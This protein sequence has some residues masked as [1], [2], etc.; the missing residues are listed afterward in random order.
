[1]TSKVITSSKFIL[2][3]SIISKIFSFAGSILLAR[4]LFPADYGYLTF[5]TVFTAFLQQIGN[6]GIEVFY[7]QEKTNNEKEEE[8]ILQTVFKLR[9]F[10]NGSLFLIQNIVAFICYLYMEESIVS[11]LLSIFSI[12][13]IIEISST[14]NSAI[15]KKELNFKPIA[16]ANTFRDVTSVVSRVLFA[17]LGFGPLCFGLGAVIGS[18]SQAI[19]ILRAKRMKVDWKFWDTLYFRRV[20]NF[21]KHVLV[22]SIGSYGSQ[23]IDK[24][25]MVSFFDVSKIGFYS[26]G[27]SNAGIPFTYIF[28][29]QQQLILS[30]SANMK[31]KPEL[32]L[33]R[34]FDMA[35]IIILLTGP[36]YIFAY[37]NC[38]LIVTS[39]FGNKWL[40]AV[41][42]VKVF[43]IY[44]FFLSFLT[45]FNGLLTAMGRPDIISRIT[46]LKVIGL[47]PFLFIFAVLVPDLVWYSF[48][49]SMISVVFD[50]IKANLGAKKIGGSVFSF[51]RRNSDVVLLL[52]LLIGMEMI[53]LKSLLFSGFSFLI[54]SIFLVFLFW[55]YFWVRR[56]DR[57]LFLKL[58]L[59]K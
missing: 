50:M 9:L 5:T 47:S 58:F 10:A 44:F 3:G 28:S 30:Y 46:L 6:F 59:K 12:T 27:Y 38:D 57:E 20:Y 21:S 15:L 35:R 33:T 11:Q 56:K 19:F 42:Y 8:G 23:Q 14:V 48:S 52:A 39:L 13:Y 54:I 18:L 32:L 26:F 1:M 34:I 55:I 43:I 25:L 7:L 16:V 53:L 49:F 41:V 36:L 51:L 24:L 31:D 4:I 2:I 45:P 22:G 37:F 40:M 17:S 29:P